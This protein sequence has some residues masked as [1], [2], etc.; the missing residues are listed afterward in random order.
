MEDETFGQAESRCTIKDGRMN[1]TYIGSMLRE[2]TNRI[3]DPHDTGRAE[4]LAG[5]PLASFRRRLAAWLIDIAL[6]AGTYI[7]AVSGLRYL[8]EER[9]GLKENVYDS[10]HVHVRLDFHGLSHMAWVL[11]LVLYF[12]LFVWRTNGLTPGKRL[13]GIRVASLTHEH[14]SLW[15]AIERALGYGASALEAGF[16][17]VQYFTNRNHCCVHDRIAETVVIRSERKPGSR[18][19]E[20]GRH[21]KISASNRVPV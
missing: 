7:P 18:A 16:G 2:R 13:L 5:T 6:V 17:F 12:G 19:G 20:D 11:W 10:A 9:L 21:G 3:F 4:A 15:Q 1:G 8:F 14:I